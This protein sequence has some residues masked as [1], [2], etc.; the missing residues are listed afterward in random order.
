MYIAGD[1]D[2]YQG[3]TRE[4]EWY[5]MKC[6][7]LRFV[8]GTLRD[9][10]ICRIVSLCLLPSI[11]GRSL[12]DDGVGGWRDQLAMVHHRRLMVV[13]GGVT[14]WRWCITVARWWPGPGY[15]IFFR[16]KAKARQK[17]HVGCGR[18]DQLVMVHHRCQMV[19]VGGVTS[20]RWCITVARWWWWA[21]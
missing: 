2:E 17:A 18:R 4:R 16:G 19:V 9:V 14:S 7:F 5:R 3:N 13:V 11:F 10:L 12:L 1:S 15:C 8:L 6:V 21:A 20:W